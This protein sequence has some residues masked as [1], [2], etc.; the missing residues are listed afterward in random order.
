MDT[1]DFDFMQTSASAAAT[2]P[3]QPENVSAEVPAEVPAEV[4]A[5]VSTSAREPTPHP[6]AMNLEAS[7]KAAAAAAAAT[8]RAYLQSQDKS[9][10]ELSQKRSRANRETRGVTAD[11]I[12]VQRT[13]KKSN[14]WITTVIFPRPEGATTDFFEIE[15]FKPAESG[16]PSN[17]QKWFWKEPEVA[18]SK[19]PIFYDTAT[20]IKELSSNPIDERL[21]VGDVVKVIGLRYDRTENIISKDPMFSVTCAEIVGNT[22]KCAWDFANINVSLAD[23]Q[24]P[25]EDVSGHVVDAC[26]AAYRNIMGTEDEYLQKSLQ[27]AAEKPSGYRPYRKYFIIP[28][29]QGFVDTETVRLQNGESC[30]AAIFPV[31]AD[32]PN[33]FTGMIGKEG[34]SREQRVLRVAIQGGMGIQ[35]GSVPFIVKQHIVGADGV[36]STMVTLSTKVYEENLSVVSTRE[37]WRDVGPALTKGMVGAMIVAPTT[38]IVPGQQVEVTGSLVWDLRR[39]VSNVGVKVP[40]ASLREFI[41]VS[42]EGDIVGEKLDTP[43]HGM[44]D[45]GKI[46]R[47]HV[48]PCMDCVNLGMITGNIQ[49]LMD[50]AERGEASFMIVGQK[51]EIETIADIRDLQSKGEAEA[52]VEYQKLVRMPRTAV[53]KNDY[54]QVF[55]CTPGQNIMTLIDGTETTKA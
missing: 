21:Q 46:P 25:W 27:E 3:P 35:T 40:V 30:L 10:Q 23:L 54:F 6:R 14:I 18:G 19:W 28:I 12:I 17:N 50:A 32:D 15:T 34:Q 22:E 16:K 24:K 48:R 31:N 51:L 26:L 1:K 43:P 44:G 38:V 45:D 7:R 13:Q 41:T 29:D 39:T 37:K 20:S 36:K 4:S 33:T 8:R 53:R 5:E 55:A 47:R 49:R 9:T 42:P 11:A 2:P 52:F